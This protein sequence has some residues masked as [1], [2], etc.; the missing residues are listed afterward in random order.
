MI[1]LLK[2]LENYF[3]SSENYFLSSGNSNGELSL[4]A[5]LNDE[6][7]STVPVLSI[8]SS[9]AN[10]QNSISTSIIFNLKFENSDSYIEK[11]SITVYSIYKKEVCTFEKKNGIVCFKWCKIKIL[12]N[13]F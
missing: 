2:K 10:K 9:D 1:I 6:S 3:L 5:L 4:F 13:H 12:W 8:I 7:Q 11:H